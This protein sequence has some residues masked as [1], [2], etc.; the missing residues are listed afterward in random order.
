MSSS[1]H[2]EDT[3]SLSGQELGHATSV[4]DRKFPHDFLDQACRTRT[5]FHSYMDW[6]NTMQQQDRTSPVFPIHTVSEGRRNQPELLPAEIG[7]TRE[8]EGQDYADSYFKG[9]VFAAREAHEA[10]AYQQQA[11]L[12]PYAV[13]QTFS[14]PTPDLFIVAFKCARAGTFYVP[15]NTGLEV[16]VGDNVIVEGDRGVDLGTVTH[17]QVTLAEAKQ[18]TQAA[19]DAHFKWL[20][21]FSK[22]KQAPSAGSVGV[23]TAAPE[24]PPSAGGSR[25]QST[26]SKAEDRPKMIRSIATHHQIQQLREKEG[27]EA[28]AKR[29]A[30]VKVGEHGLEM[31]ILDAEMQ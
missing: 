19:K 22:T 20:M 3:G 15:P 16:K 31:E 9:E 29:V 11:T 30:Q 23:M 27:A 21:M 4:D 26:N 14:T 25:G 1:L 5:S 2:S 7:A 12:N 18:L 13:P 6:N 28:K 17:A 10:T 8:E 24:E